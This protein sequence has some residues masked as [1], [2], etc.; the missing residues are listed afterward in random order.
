MEEVNLLTEEKPRAIK[1][2]DGK[3]Y[4]LPP[5]NITT[6]ANIEKTMGVG[7]K[8]LSLKME[9]EPV[10]SI[11][12][13]VWALLKQTNPDLTLEKAGTLVDFKSIKEFSEYLTII[14]AM[15]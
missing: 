9:N 12:L 10:Q 1:L 2:A 4:S 11:Q 3:E 5:L 8:K 6:L 13:F 14:L 7:G 15:S